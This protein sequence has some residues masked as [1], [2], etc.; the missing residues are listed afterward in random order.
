MSAALISGVLA[1]LAMGS[2]GASVDGALEIPTGDA[3]SVS[4]R[5]VSDSAV[6][7][8]LRFG[9]RVG[10]FTHRAGETAY[11]IP[12]PR[13]VEGSRLEVSTDPEVPLASVANTGSGSHV[14]PQWRP[15]GGSVDLPP[16]VEA[17]DDGIAV[18]S[19]DE[20]DTYGL[21]LFGVRV[22]S[23]PVTDA[24]VVTTVYHGARLE[25]ECWAEGSR[26]TNGF[27]HEDF[28]DARAY[29]STLWFKVRIPGGS[30][31]F[32]PDARFSRSADAGRLGLQRCE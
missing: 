27:D 31:G 26:V 28:D 5:A 23:T 20:T 19:V 11:E 21:R 13:A 4:I 29:E 10:S 6:S 16:P 30:T 18:A 12:L 3:T 8:D 25:A 14:Y 22:R 1:T 17:D 2:L 7:V 15:E 32:I 24:P 9:N